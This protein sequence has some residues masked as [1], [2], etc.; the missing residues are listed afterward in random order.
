MSFDGITMSAV[1]REL[2]SLLGGAKIEKI[3]SRGQMK[4]SCLSEQKGTFSLLCSPTQL[5]RIH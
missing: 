3:I 5:A 4:L 2:A 1:R